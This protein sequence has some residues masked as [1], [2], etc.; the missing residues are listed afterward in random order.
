MRTFFKC[1]IVAFIAFIATTTAF[2]Q[3]WTKAQKEVWQIVED[4]WAKWKA[5]DI[6]GTLAC[7]HEKYQGWN[8]QAPLPMTKE[9][10]MQRYQEMKDVFKIN[11]YGL[12]PARIVI[13]DNAAVVDYYY[14]YDGTYMQGDKKEPVEDHG[15]NAEFYVKEDGKWMLIGDMTTIKERKNNH[16]DED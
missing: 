1:A 2:T 12:N 11:Y 5:G 15:Q 9:M 10:V 16:D 8:D 3:E 4:S 6:Q 7:L 14:W 13:T